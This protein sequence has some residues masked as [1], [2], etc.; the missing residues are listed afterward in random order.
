MNEIDDEIAKLLVEDEPILDDGTFSAAVRRRIARR[1]KR[2]LATKL[3]LM[4]VVMAAATAFVA[5]A[6]NGVMF[7]PLA[8]GR[9]LASPLVAILACGV[10]V[11]WNRSQEA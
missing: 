11:W 5:F 1:R 4:V 2:V 8:M 10:M 7:P 9:L 3:G 6:P